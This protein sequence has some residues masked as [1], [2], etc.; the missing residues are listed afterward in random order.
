MENRLR[1][2]NWRTFQHYKDRCP[3]WVKLHFKMLTSRDWVSASDS[4]RVL[5]V[6]CMLIASQDAANDGSFD[7]DPE[8][9]TRVAYLNSSP[10]FN[11]LIK[12]GFL[13]TLADASG[14]KQKIQ[15]SSPETEEETER[16]TETKKSADAS[17]AAGYV[18]DKLPWTG[19]DARWAYEDQIKKGIRQFNK[20]AEDVA[21]LMVARWEQYDASNLPFKS[22]VKTFITTG[23]WMNPDKWRRDNAPSGKFEQATKGLS[24]YLS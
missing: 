14:C 13:E 8:Y 24:E 15:K 23:L 12:L 17:F 9:F 21:E 18:L 3:P 7:A 16:E 20:P 11:S 10:D 19:M 6:A 2:R 22:N 4:E 1:I 5:A